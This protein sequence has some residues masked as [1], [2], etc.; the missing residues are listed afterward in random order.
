MPVDKR[1]SIC[2]VGAG[3]AGALLALLLARAGVSVL[4]IERSMLNKRAFRGESISPDSVAMLHHL[5]IMPAIEK[6]GYLETQQLH[7]LDAQRCLLKVNFNSFP[8]LHR[9]SIDIPQLVL[10]HAILKEAQKYQNFEFIQGVQ[11]QGLLMENNEVRGVMLEQDQKI[12]RIQAHL[13]VGADG[14]YGKI[15]SWAGIPAKIKPLPRDIIWFLLP[16]PKGWGGVAKISMHQDQHLIALPTYPN[17]LRVGVNIKRGQYAKMRAGPISQLHH[18]VTR[19]DP[20]LSQGLEEN[21]LS[22]SDTALLDIFTAEVDTWARDGLILIGD[23]AHTLT[24]VLGQGVNQALKDAFYLAPIIQKQDFKQG[25]VA[26][27]PSLIFQDFIQERKRAVRFIHRFQMQQEKRLASQSVLGVWK[28]RALYR[29]MHYFP[30]IQ[31]Y[32]WEKIAYSDQKKWAESRL[33]S[34]LDQS[35]V[36]AFSDRPRC[37]GKRNAD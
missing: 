1:V 31:R 18:L 32:L 17:F 20:V 4:L 6:H 14:R 29:L 5:G 15:R 13:V 19:L 36:I 26:G 11:C 7:I 35:H 33:I 16:R 2:I 27:L 24:P 23:A 37:A 12:R 21:L 28:R 25:E 3:P 9:F 22:W 8:Y 30:K 34:T 10:I